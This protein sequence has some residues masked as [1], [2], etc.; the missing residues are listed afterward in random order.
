MPFKNLKE[1]ELIPGYRVR[2]IHSKDMTFAYWNIEK[3]APLPEHSHLH[4]QVA[5]IMQGKFE[6]KIG[7]ET[8]VLEPRDVAIIPPKV[9]H[10]GK[11]ITKCKI[12]DVFYPIR[13]DYI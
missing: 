5:N 11:A 8:K 13:E 2:F 1:K 7:D 6:L 4:E 9:K 3:D 12:I 10:S